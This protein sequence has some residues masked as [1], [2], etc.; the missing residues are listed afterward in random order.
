MIQKS[1]EANRIQVENERKE[2]EAQR[3]HEKNR[4]EKNRQSRKEELKIILGTIQ[5]MANKD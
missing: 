1:D 4:N 5:K 3:K 2:R